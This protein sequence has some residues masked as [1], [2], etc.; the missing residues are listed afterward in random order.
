MNSVEPEVTVTI[1]LVE[2][3]RSAAGK[4]SPRMR[5]SV[6]ILWGLSNRRLRLVATSEQ[7]ITNAGANP[8][9]IDRLVELVSPFLSR[10][11]TRKLSCRLSVCSQLSGP[12]RSPRHI[13]RTDLG[14]ARP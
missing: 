11:K 1:V 6:K 3:D 4:S 2:I 13:F 8:K 12:R 5:E 9:P 10:S 14:L 7:S